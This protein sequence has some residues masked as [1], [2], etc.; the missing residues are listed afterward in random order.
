MVTTVFKEKNPK[1][2]EIDK[3]AIKETIDLEKNIKAAYF[4]I[5]RVP[6]KVD[7]FRVQL[8][9][10]LVNDY[11]EIRDYLAKIK[12]ESRNILKF[13]ILDFSMSLKGGQKNGNEDR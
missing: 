3:V 9:D 12:K 6:G 10:D 8:D 2:L 11:S 7:D 13:G 1:K 4:W 5:G